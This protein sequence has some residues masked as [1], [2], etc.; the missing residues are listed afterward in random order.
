MLEWTQRGLTGEEISLQIASRNA[1]IM[2]T[3]HHDHL[4]RERQAHSKK[5]TTM[6]CRIAELSC[7]LDEAKSS[8]KKARCD[9]QKERAV[10]KHENKR[11]GTNKNEND[12]DTWK[13]KW[14][15]QVDRA[16]AMDNRMKV[17]TRQLAVK[18]GQINEWT[19]W[20][21][22]PIKLPFSLVALRVSRF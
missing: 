4:K 9:L 22:G 21:G 15:K 19:E 20:C 6:E 17:M 11:K 3:R 8:T 13:D 12:S 1:E 10:R 18:Q 7:L 2:N 16:R 14:M 5:E